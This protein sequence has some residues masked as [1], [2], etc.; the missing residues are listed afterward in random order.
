MVAAAPSAKAAPGVVTLTD[1]KSHWLTLRLADVNAQQFGGF[2]PV[3]VATTPVPVKP[4]AQFVLLNISA[5]TI[6]PTLKELSR[7]LKDRPVMVVFCG[8]TKEFRLNIA[9]EVP[10]AKKSLL[11]IA[12][13]VPK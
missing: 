6:C 13:S 4:T 7:I 2:G 5:V 11:P 9:D 8:M 3:T 12:W 10:S 1:T